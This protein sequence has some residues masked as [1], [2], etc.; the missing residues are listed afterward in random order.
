MER[1]RLSAGVAQSF[2]TRKHACNA[3]FVGGDDRYTDKCTR[4]NPPTFLPPGPKAGGK[5]KSES[6][7]LFG[8]MLFIMAQQDV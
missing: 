8:R 3:Q 2:L 5:C 1:V 4:Y 6:L 7:L